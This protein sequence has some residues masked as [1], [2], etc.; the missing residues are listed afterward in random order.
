MAMLIALIPSGLWV[1]TLICTTFGI[2]FR[3]IAVRILIVVHHLYDLFTSRL[4]SC[5]R[6]DWGSYEDYISNS[7]TR[8]Y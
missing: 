5:V 8:P 6:I 2:M 3:L 1:L 4:A 7:L